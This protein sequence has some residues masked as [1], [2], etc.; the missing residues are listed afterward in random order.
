[1]LLL[2]D[3]SLTDRGGGSLS[4]QEYPLLVIWACYASLKNKRAIFMKRLR[5]TVKIKVQILGELRLY[6]LYL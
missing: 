2:V 1:M 3:P 5:S 4:A 6:I